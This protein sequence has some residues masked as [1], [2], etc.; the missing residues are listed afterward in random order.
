MDGTT[1]TGKRLQFWLG[2]AISLVCLGALFFFI[3]PA[4]ILAALQTTRYDYLAL[5]GLALLVFMLLRAVRWR[6]MLNS[7]RA[8][9][10]GVP[11]SKVFHIQ[12][13]GYLLTNILPF[14]VG[15]VARAVLVGNV[16]P[17]TIAQG[18]STM[19]VERVFDFL[20]IIILF[21]FTL[22]AVSDLPADTQAVV[23]VVGV[24]TIVAAAVLVIAAN[25]R[26]LAGRMATRI[27]DRVPFLDTAAWVKRLDNLLLGLNV[28]TRFKDGL[29]LLVLSVV[30]WLPII[31]GYWLAL[32]AVHLETSLAEAAF[33]VCIAAFSLTAP[34]S[35][36]GVGVFEG[37]VTFALVS[38]L[39]R[40]E[41]ASAS[42]AFLYHALN[43][44]LLAILGVI[45]IN[46]TSATFGSVLA[47]A[48]AAMPAKSKSPGYGG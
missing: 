39:H 46:R 3:K 28:L 29:I 38:I 16:P 45:G 4:D 15:D 27:L 23:Q 9:G 41:A 1:T 18:L 36:G 33:V 7:G 14:R 31:A 25:Q 13:I 21:P 10:D 2:I 43:Y 11:Y 22:V 6:F 40:P 48:R 26:A 30:V 47:S 8:G 42:F 34:S 32:R 37:S 20:F 19:V 5:A 44:L 17:V 12:S 35:P 24:L